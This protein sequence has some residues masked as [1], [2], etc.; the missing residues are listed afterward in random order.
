MREITLDATVENIDVAIKFIND[1]LIKLSCSEDNISL[2]DIAIDEIFGNIARY[3]YPS[4]NGIV[5][6]KFD[7]INEA[8]TVEISFI[9]E[10]IEYN[11][12]DKE[13]PDVTLSLDEREI[14]GLG[15]YIVKNSMDDVNYEYVDNKNILQIVKKI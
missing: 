4:Q 5:T 3:A 10:G 8:K 11:P 7:T 15:I 1:E 2:I 6:I 12:L 13:D 14:G 9:D